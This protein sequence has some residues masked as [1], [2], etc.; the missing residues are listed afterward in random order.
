MV[1]DFDQN[2]E[3]NTLA[4]SGVRK[5]QGYQMISKKSCGPGRIGERVQWRQFKFRGQNRDVIA[6]GLLRN[7]REPKRFEN[8]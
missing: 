5:V 2:Q 1:G 8:P 3:Q 6:H 7:R 4:S